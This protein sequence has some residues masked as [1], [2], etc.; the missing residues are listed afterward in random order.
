MASLGTNVGGIFYTVSLD[1]AEMI[2]GQ[3][4]AQQSLKETEGSIERFGA[5]LSSITSAIKLYAA[6][7]AVVKVAQ[8]ADSFK[9]LASR[10]E[11][12]AGGLEK[13]AEAM[14]ALQ[15]IAQSTQ[16]ELAGNVQ[17]FARLN[18]S[19]LQMGG[20]QQDTLRVTDLLAKSIKLSGASAQESTAAMLQFGQALGSGKLA[21]DELRSLME[22]APYLMQ[23]L[24]DGIGVPIGSLKSLGEQGKLTADVVVEA[25]SSAATKINADFAKVPQTVGGAFDVMTDKAAE[26]AAAM[27]GAT[28]FTTVLVGAV[29]GLGQVLESLARQFGG[30][31][32]EADKLGRNGAIKTWADGTVSVLS[33]VVDAADLVVRGFLQMGKAIGGTAAAVGAAARGEFSQART[34]MGQMADEVLRIGNT[35]YA[36]AK[37]RQQQAALAGG[38][39]GSDRLDRMA[40]GGGAGSRLK[41]TTPQDDGKPKFD[42]V[43]YLNGLRA[44]SADAMNEIDIIEKE[45]LRKNAQLLEQG[46]INR[47][48][49]AEATVLIEQAAAG[50]RAEIQRGLDDLIA[51]STEEMDR[52]DKKRA[53]D[54]ARGQEYARG[55]ISDQ[56]PITKLQFEL[57]AKRA[58][59]QQYYENDKENQ[60]LY[61]QARV[62]LEQETEKKI[63]EIREDEEQKRNAAQQQLLQGY[64]SMFG[65]MADITDAFG[66]KTSKAYR[67]LFAVS[68]AFAIADSIVQIQAGMAKAL[69]APFPANIAQMAAVGA[70]GATLLATIKSTN[71]GGGRRFGGSVSEGS[72][73]R[74]NESGRPEMYTSSTG[75]QYMLPTQGGNVTP[76]DKVGAGSKPTIIF[77]NT[78]TP[79]RMV[80]E[81]Y[82]EK[83]NTI[84]MVVA[85]IAE[86]IASNR[87]PIWS[88][89]KSA[90]SV[91]SKL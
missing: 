43:G 12:A 80:S 25:L 32:S 18:S 44:A 15:R 19:I 34:I 54:Q 30:A 85:D 29:T 69:N 76:A 49:A 78:G 39:D 5:K 50:K 77:Q 3:R 40:A 81:S 21:G 62:A 37:I 67:A 22:A 90:T 65:A 66:G 79:Q 20:N 4:R 9:L 58:L 36:G 8:M 31:N 28:G 33:Y 42:A 59:I 13:G 27:D 24:A 87:G 73:Y 70:Q 72:L 61:A 47:Q 56:N 6:A 14:A 10:V 64:G 91:Q 60:L 46:K 53:E 16:T 7:L 89:M 11:I 57:E 75:Q 1:T 71:Y 74:V 55:V 26:A 48:Q 35:P 84:R 88:A 2:R 51:K 41:A 23:R 52:R 68:K 82:D 45:A 83:S 17:V 38:T 86:Q 63:R